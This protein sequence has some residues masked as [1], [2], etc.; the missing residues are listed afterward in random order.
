MFHVTE[1]ADVMI[2]DY[3]K[4]KA[5]DYAIRLYKTRGGAEE[6]SLCLALDDKREDDVLFQER[7]L[8]FIINRDLFERAKPIKVDFIAGEKNFGFTV[9][10]NF[11]KAVDSAGS[12]PLQD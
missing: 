10:A 7:T 11:H 1:M 8:T 5:K 12:I 9:I 3:I 2:K 4:E 6:P